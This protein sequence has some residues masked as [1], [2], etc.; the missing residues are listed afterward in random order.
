M[1]TPPTLH[2]GYGKITFL[3]IDAQFKGISSIVTAARSFSATFAYR[4]L[5]NSTALAAKR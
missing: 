5:G 1:S 4:F 2:V 3:P